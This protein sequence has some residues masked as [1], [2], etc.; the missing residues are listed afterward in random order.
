MLE[1]LQNALKSDTIKESCQE[2]L[3]LQDPQLINHVDSTNFSRSKNLNSMLL[4][5]QK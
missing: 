1:T 4:T 5:I 2:P 3:D